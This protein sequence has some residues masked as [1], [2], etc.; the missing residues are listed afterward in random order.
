MLFFAEEMYAGLRTVDMPESIHLGGW[1]KADK[2]K[3]DKGLEKKMG[4]VRKI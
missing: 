3:I 4:G 2:R 1:P